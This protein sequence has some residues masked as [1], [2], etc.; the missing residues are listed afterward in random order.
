MRTH[1]AAELFQRLCHKLKPLPREA[2]RGISRFPLM[3]LP[4]ADPGILR[5]FEET[6]CDVKTE[7]AARRRFLE[8]L[9]DDVPESDFYEDLLPDYTTA[10]EVFSVLASPNEYEIVQVAREPFPTNVDCLGFDVGYWG[11]DHYSIICDSAVCPLWHPPQPECF[12]ELVR[13]LKMVNESFLFPSAE[14]AAQF[15]SWYRTQHWAE[16]ESRPDE[17]CIIQVNK[18]R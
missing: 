16:T 8:L 18:P 4:S 15:R 1:E 6:G 14:G 13:E 7:Q 3:P 5:T 2:Y 11:G 10:R 17:F 12:D 9:G